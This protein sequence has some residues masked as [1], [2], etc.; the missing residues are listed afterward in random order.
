[1]NLKNNCVLITGGSEGIGLEIAKLL[2]AN[3]KVIVCGRSER[4]LNEAQQQLPSLITI[5]C[6]ITNSEDRTNLVKTIKLKH[7]EL[8]LLINNAGARQPT[9]LINRLDWKLPLEEDLKINFL[10][11]VLLCQDLLPV[12]NQQ[13]HPAIVNM[14]TGL[15]HLPKAAQ[16]FYCAAK[17]ANRSFTQSLRWAYR[18]SNLKV[19]EV[20]LPL[21][22]TNFHQGNLPNS[23]SA[24]TPLEAAEKTLNG[25]AKDKE[26]I[27]IGKAKLA[28]FLA[29]LAP[30]KGL[31]IVNK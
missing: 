21:V 20:I 10:A 18:K 9:D 22:D 8:N 30:Q 26:E 19:F 13:T 12:L 5:Q 16:A 24:M 7:P 31:A 17:A 29:L 23:L 14:T 15:V 27:K 11:P 1:M 4:K 25:L 28:Q 6:D 3:N 2:T